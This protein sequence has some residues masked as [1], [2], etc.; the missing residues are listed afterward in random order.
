MVVK[1]PDPIDVHVGQRLRQRR[2]LAGI[3][4]EKLAEAIGVSFQM[5]QKY[6]KGTCRVG[7]SRLMQV[8][9]VLKVSAAYFFDE[10]KGAKGGVMA[11]PTTVP[12]LAEEGTTL[13][14]EVLTRKETID[15]L[16]AYYALPPASR[17]LVLEM[18]K[19]LGISLNQKG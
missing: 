17:K 19:G 7:A 18:A 8:A 11:T 4:Q 10:F 16:K 5:V 15:L 6:E 1:I 3:T 12:Q 9:Q 13:N 2:M 14:D